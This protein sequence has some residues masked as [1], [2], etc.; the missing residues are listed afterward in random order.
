MTDRRIEELERQNEWLRQQA[1]PWFEATA[2]LSEDDRNALV[3]HLVRRSVELRRSAE[4]VPGWFQSHRRG[5]QGFA[6]R[7]RDTGDVRELTFAAERDLHAV[8]VQVGDLVEVSDRHAR[9]LRR[10]P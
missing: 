4:I 1:E 9:I 2:G 5:H 3:K 6:I 7:E 10:A 8:G